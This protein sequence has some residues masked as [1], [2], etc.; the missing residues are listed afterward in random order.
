M[1]PHRG[2]STTLLLADIDFFKRIN[3]CFEAGDR[4]LVVAQKRCFPP[5][6]ERDTEGHRYLAGEVQ[7]QVGPRGL[8]MK[9][10]AAHQHRQEI[11][12]RRHQP[13]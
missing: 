11:L 3:D 1:P 10:P 12:H 4:V 13:F 8:R 5:H 7:E 2:F 9:R 6:D